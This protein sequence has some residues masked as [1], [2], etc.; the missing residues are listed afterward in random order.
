MTEPIGEDRSSLQS[1]IDRLRGD[2]EKFVEGA[3]TRGAKAWEAF[4]NAEGG[5][6]RAPVIDIMETANSLE[7]LVNLPGAGPEDINVVLDGNVLT[8]QA[9]LPAAP[10]G[11]TTH[12]RERVAGR[13]ARSIPLPSP[14]Q[15]GLPEAILSN[16][17][18][19][20]TLEKAASSKSTRVPIRTEI[21]EPAQPSGTAAP[22]SVD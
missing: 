5:R 1:S 8:V 14:V 16:G 10:S 19:K 22:A 7:I 15:A 20:I 17:V 9:D 13:I 2:F 12:L 6:E 21:N 4:G 11:R 3:V 18:L